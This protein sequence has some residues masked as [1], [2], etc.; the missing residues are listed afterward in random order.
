MNAWELKAKLRRKKDNIYL[1]FC[2]KNSSPREK[3]GLATM[4]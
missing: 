2:N 4:A 1:D 3:T